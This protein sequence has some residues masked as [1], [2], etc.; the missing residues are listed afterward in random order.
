MRN[1]R[2]RFEIDFPSGFTARKARFQDVVARMKAEVDG[3]ARYAIVIAHRVTARTFALIDDRACCLRQLEVDVR[4]LRL[5][6]R[7]I[8]LDLR[9]FCRVDLL[10]TE[11]QVLLVGLGG[12]AIPLELER[13]KPEVPKHLPA[14]DELVGLAKLDA[15]L[16]VASTVRILQQ[17]D[18][19]FE[20]ALALLD[21]A[22]VGERLGRNER[23]HE[24]GDL[25]P[26]VHDEKLRLALLGVSRRALPTGATPLYCAAASYFAVSPR[27]SGARWSRWRVTTSAPSMLFHA[28]RTAAPTSGAGGGAGTSNYKRGS[29][30]S[31]PGS[32]EDAE[33]SENAERSM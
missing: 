7:Q 28:T 19:R 10:A 27:T 17:D 20:S 16:F 12:L 9:S 4:H 21:F 5:E 11:C 22:V 6:R 2:A 29:K 1:R 18:A 33:V 25:G 32:F 31:D 13:A 15:S 14:S 8:A 23:R 24:K 26:S 3:E 30:I